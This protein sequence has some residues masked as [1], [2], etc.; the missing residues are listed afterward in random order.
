M[1]FHHL[2][3]ADQPTTPYTS[4]AEFADDKIIYTSQNDLYT[5][6]L[7]LQ[8]HLNSLSS[9]YTKWKI[10]I[11]NEKSSHITFSL[12]Q[13]EIPSIILNNQTIPTVS[14]IRY[15]GLTLD[16]RLTWAEQIK[17]KPNTLNLRRKSLHYLIG[18]HSQLNL[19]T[20]LLIYKQLLMPIWT[21]GI[22]VWDA[23]KLSNLN[24]I[25]RFQSIT[26]HDNQGPLLRIQPHTPHRP[27]H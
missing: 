7:Y 4:V 6:K 18:N 10:K 21:Y 13:G 17:I 8:N 14:N 12:R 22:Q 16:K 26:K 11:N 24:K 3:T 20:K 2:Y 5:A 23:A 19:N 25:Q 27:T 9:W 1:L 15:L